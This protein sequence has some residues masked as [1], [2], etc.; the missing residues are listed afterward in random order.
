MMIFGVIILSLNQRSLK[1]RKNYTTVTGKSGQLTKINIGKAGKHV[2]GIIFIVVTFFTSIWPILLFALETFL[3]NSGDYSFLYTG[4]MNNLTTKWWLTSDN[5]AENGMYGQKGI[6]Y[7]STIWHAFG[8]TLM[9][10]VVCALI[11][12]T[13]GTLIGY[14][15]SKNRRSKWANYVNNV[16]FLPYLMPLCLHCMFPVLFH[17][18]SMHS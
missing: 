14:A 3:P 8:G 9:L 17:Y 12:G 15:V 5:V 2:V 4:D 18:P 16:A 10:A 6:L 1:S 11:A 13:I 7:N